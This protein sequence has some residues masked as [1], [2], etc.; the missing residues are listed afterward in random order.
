VKELQALSC[1]DCGKSFTRSSTLNEHR[2]RHGEDQVG[3]AHGGD[4]QVGQ[5]PHGDDHQGKELQPL[6]CLDCGKSF[7]RSSTLNEHR[8]RHGEDQVGQAHGGDHQVGQ[9]PHGDDH[10]GKELQPLSC[11]DCGKSFTRSSALNEHQRRHGEHQVGQQLHG[12]NQVGQHQHLH[13]KDHQVKELQALSCLD[14]GKSFTRSSA[15]NEH[16]RR[17]G[18]Q[19]FELQALSCLD[20]GKSFTRSSALNEHQRRHGEDQ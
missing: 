18:E 1:L 10:Q 14:C 17:H 4:H 9:H 20:C 11:L 19:Q 13:D 8:R 15:L 2:R 6:S 5:H 7:T 3:Q 12:E 16:Q